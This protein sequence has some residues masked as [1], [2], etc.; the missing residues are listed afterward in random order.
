MLSG[1][2]FAKIFTTISNLLSAYMRVTQVTHNSEIL[3]KNSGNSEPR[4]F[5]NMRGSIKSA[6]NLKASSNFRLKKFQLFWTK[7]SVLKRPHYDDS[8]RA[9]RHQ[10]KDSS[11]ASSFSNCF[12]ISLL[13]RRVDWG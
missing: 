5:S 13:H 2:T 12:L 6:F 3:E 8:L 1:F 4:S 7:L 9:G 11:A 10:S